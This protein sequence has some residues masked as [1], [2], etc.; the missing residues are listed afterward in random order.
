[1]VELYIN[2]KFIGGEFVEELYNYNVEDFYLG[3]ANPSKNYENYY[4]KGLIN[5]FAVFDKVLST[6]EME[7]IY[8]ESTK[9]SLLNNFGKYKSSKN[10]KIYY[11]FKHYRKDKLIDISGNEFNAEIVNC[12]NNTLVNSKFMVEAIV[13][14]KKECKFKS[15]KH[16]NN[17]VEGNRWVHEETRKNQLRFNSIKE[18]ALF[19][20]IEGLNTLR[21]KKVEEKELSEKAKMISIEL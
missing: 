5:E 3:V 7:Q 18:E 17:S 6:K 14:Y 13:P 19:Y 4:F 10:L 2:G 8:R 16:T 11:D 20:S 9:K 15:L 1:M 21:Y 12:Q